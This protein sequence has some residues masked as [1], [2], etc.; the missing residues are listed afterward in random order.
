MIHP[1]YGL[2]FQKASNVW[3][4]TDPFAKKLTPI[5]LAWWLKQPVLQIDRARYEMRDMLSE[6]ANTQGAHADR[7]RDTI[8][9]QIS[10]HWHGIYLNIFTL[11]VGIYLSNQFADSVSADASLRE[12]IIRRYPEIMEDLY[13]VGANLTWGP[14]QLRIEHGDMTLHLGGETELSTTFAIKVPPS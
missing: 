11:R 2:S 6:V 1:L 14:E 5:K 12:R 3:T 9:Q 7:R 4:S 10:E 8:R 13:T